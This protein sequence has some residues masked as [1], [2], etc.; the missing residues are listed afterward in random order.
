MRQVLI[1]NVHKITMNIAKPLH[2]IRYDIVDLKE[3]QD[4]EELIYRATKSVS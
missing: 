2:D 3:D 4:A 1:N